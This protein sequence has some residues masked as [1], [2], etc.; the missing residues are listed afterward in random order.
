[1]PL[2][3]I[4]K[5]MM[6]RRLMLI[7]ILLL[8][9][10]L[11]LTYRSWV[12]PLLTVQDPLQKSDAIVVLGGDYSGKRLA[13]AVKLYKEGWADHLI[14]SGGVLQ[15]W[16][17]TE[18]DIMREQALTLGVPNQAMYLEDRSTTTYENALFTL[19]VIKAHRWN[20][21]I[22]VTDWDHS[23]RAQ[24]IFSH[25]YRKAGIRV[26]SAP[27]LSES[28]FPPDTWWQS[29]LGTEKVLTNLIGIPYYW[30]RYGLLGWT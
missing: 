6:K 1:M 14:F 24:W 18:A 26:I 16:K 20:S 4:L 17:S 22:I 10:A 5:G 30:L 25:L 23:R 11:T 8:L 27:L 3:D 19:N 13:Y 21:C 12:P 15:T 2:S 9:A 7:S 28:R 29:H